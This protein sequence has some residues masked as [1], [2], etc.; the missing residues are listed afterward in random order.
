MKSADT[1]GACSQSCP[2][3]DESLNNPGARSQLLD[4]GWRVGK[5]T[6]LGMEV[7][8]FFPRF[9]VGLGRNSLATDHSRKTEF[10]KEHYR[11]FPVGWW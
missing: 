8:M 9:L 1:S 11:T 7:G 2:A 6:H 5:L 3:R 4:S 10:K